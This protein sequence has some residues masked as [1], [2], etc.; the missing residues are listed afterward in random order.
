[1]IPWGIVPRLRTIL[2]ALAFAV[3]AGVLT[4]FRVFVYLVE[5]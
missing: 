3:A 4:A 1:M 2:I 5:Q